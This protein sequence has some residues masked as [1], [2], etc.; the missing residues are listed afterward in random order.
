M[1]RPRR[2][3]GREDLTKEK[4]RSDASASGEELLYKGIVV[5]VRVVQPSIPRRQQGG[6]LPSGGGPVLAQ[7]REFRSERLERVEFNGALDDATHMSGEG[8]L[9]MLP[10]VTALRPVTGPDGVEDGQ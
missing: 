2:P 5:R 6:L 8:R 9:C 7:E 4:G 10:Q 3:R 1:E